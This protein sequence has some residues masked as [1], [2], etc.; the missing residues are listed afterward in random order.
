MIATPTLSLYFAR[1]FAKMTGIIFLVVFTL[2]A[3]VDYLE[4][5]RRAIQRANFN[6]LIYLAISLTRVPTVVEHALPFTV[7]F[8]SMASFVLANR[9]LELVVARASGVSAWG[10]V[11]PACVVALLFGIVASTAFNPAATAL[12]EQSIAILNRLGDNALGAESGA[13]QEN[14]PLWIRQSGRDGNWILGAKHSFNQGLSLSGVSAFVFDAKGQLDRRID[15]RSAD[16]D[17]GEWVLADGTITR[18]G[19]MP[20]PFTQMRLATDLGPAQV[21]QRLADPQTI[22]FWMLPQFIELSRKSGIP[23]SGYEMRFQTLLAQPVLFLAMVLVAATVTLRFSRSR[24][25]GQV[26]LTG[27]VVGF[28]L[29]VVTELAIGLGRS[30]VVSPIVAAWLPSIVASLASVTVLLYRE[31]G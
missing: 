4:L 22:S 7:L 6:A 18:A 16:Y 2:I 17:A 9:Q 27:I 15:A 24:D 31:D 1:R 19:T 20:A 12:K 26:I 11:L 25:L 5:A 30:G 21:S 10:F 28:V 23:S 3:F 8:A 29:Y 13:T 14:K